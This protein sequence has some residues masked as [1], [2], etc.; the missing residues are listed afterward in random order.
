MQICCNKQK[1]RMYKL[2]KIITWPYNLDL[3][4]NKQILSI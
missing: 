2:D 3:Q 1:I 4:K